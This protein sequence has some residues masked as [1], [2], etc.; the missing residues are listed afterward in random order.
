[1]ARVIFSMFFTE[2]IRFLT[3]RCDAMALGRR[4]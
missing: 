3:S 2:E 4:R 1:M